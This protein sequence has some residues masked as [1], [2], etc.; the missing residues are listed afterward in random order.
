MDSASI[1]GIIVAVVSALGMVIGINHKHIRA[2]VKSKCCGKESNIDVQFD[3][4]PVTEI[5]RQDTYQ[6]PNYKIKI[7]DRP[8]PKILEG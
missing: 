8:M 4:S 2:H 5:K 7:S 6:E 1:G 3:G